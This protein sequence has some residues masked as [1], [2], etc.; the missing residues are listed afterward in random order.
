MDKLAIRSLDVR[1]ITFRMTVAAMAM[2]LSPF[3]LGQQ[4]SK[5]VVERKV[6][7]KVAPAYPELARKMNIRG[8]VKVGIVIAPNGNVKTTS[9]VGGNPLLVEAAVHAIRQWKYA[10]E[11]GE[12]NQTGRSE[13]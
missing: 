6:V 4:D 7:S 10:P 9:V 12:S 2:L 1:R 11:A 13:V 5:T 8:T 3:V